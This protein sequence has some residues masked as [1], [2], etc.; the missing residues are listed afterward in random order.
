MKNV[1]IGI[2]IGIAIAVT[3]YHAYVVYQ[4]RAQ[5]IQNTAVM[6][7][8]TNFLNESIKKA[9]EANKTIE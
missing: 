9:E 5:V 8:V 4:L 3:A 1:L 6:T 7:E 2:A